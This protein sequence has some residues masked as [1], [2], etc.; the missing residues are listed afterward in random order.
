MSA[1]G[2][3]RAQMHF[4]RYGLWSLLLSWVPIIGDPLTVVAGLLRVPFWVFLGLVTLAKG[5]RYLL[6]AWLAS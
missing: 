2:L 1:A 3:Q 6:L 4:Q 5:G